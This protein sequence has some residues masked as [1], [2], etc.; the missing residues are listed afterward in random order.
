MDVSAATSLIS[1]VGFPIVACVYM[2]YLN[3]NMAEKH[4]V[5]MD[6]MKDAI[7]ANTNVIAKLET[8]LETFITKGE[9]ENGNAD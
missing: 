4:K 3:Q 2:F 8:L 7:N 9:K 1:S 6:G 5:E